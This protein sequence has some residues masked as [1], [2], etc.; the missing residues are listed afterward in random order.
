M[1]E[2]KAPKQTE[3]ARTRPA[4]AKPVVKERH[5][6]AFSFVSMLFL[7]ALLAAGV[8]TYLWYNQKTQSDSLGSD[9]SNARAT[10]STLRAQIDKLKKQNANL[11]NAVVDQVA[12]GDGGQQTDDDRIK[13][14]VSAWIK[15]HKDGADDQFSFNYIK[16]EAPFARA[17]VSLQ[18]SGEYSCWLKK[19]ED[20]WL[21]LF[22]GQAPPQQSELDI[23]G[24]PNSIL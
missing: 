1:E 8:M 16:K 21:V 4:E 5:S 10:E 19:S 3:T 17:G 15:G 2:P 20:V 11:G 22:C 6:R 24:V 18:P 14:V 13:A 23:W 7:L 12:N 9:I